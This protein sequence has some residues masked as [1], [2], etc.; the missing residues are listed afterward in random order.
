MAI[1]ITQEG[2][3]NDLQTQNWNRIVRMCV[4][5]HGDGGDSWGAYDE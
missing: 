2:D 1:G 4:V 5:R 3:S